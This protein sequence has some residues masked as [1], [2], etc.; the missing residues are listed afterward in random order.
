MDLFRIILLMLVIIIGIVFDIWIKHL[1]R[2]SKDVL[3]LQEYIKDQMKNPEFARE[4]EALGEECES[5]VVYDD[6]ADVLYISLGESHPGTTEEIG[7][8]VFIRRDSDTDNI[9]GITILNFKRKNEFNPNYATA[10]GDT[11]KET[12]TSTDMTQAK[13]ASL[14][15]LP[16]E[17]IAGII[18]GEEPITEEIGIELAKVLKCIPVSLW[19]NLEHNY[20]EFLSHEKDKNTRRRCK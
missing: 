5:K 12:L 1:K 19:M 6:S 17:I 15:G 8:S 20:R 9:V 2:K 11:L 7:D 3:T 16:I 4:Y 13:L 14:T 10:P 18:C